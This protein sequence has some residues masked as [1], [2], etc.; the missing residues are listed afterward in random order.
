M[1][2]LTAA[3]GCQPHSSQPGGESLLDGGY[4]GHTSVSATVTSK[5]GGG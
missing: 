1:K 4:E 2:Q 3:D 5:D